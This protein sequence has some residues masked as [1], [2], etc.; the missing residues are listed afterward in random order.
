MKSADKIILNYTL[1]INLLTKTGEMLEILLPPDGRRY[2]GR[3]SFAFLPLG[4]KIKVRLGPALAGGAHPR[5]NGWVRVLFLT[6]KKKAVPIGTAFLFWL[7]KQD[8]NLRPPGY[9]L[10]FT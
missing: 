7:R 3:D 9:E 6:E 4:A 1:K 8:S 2:T 10:R 5:R